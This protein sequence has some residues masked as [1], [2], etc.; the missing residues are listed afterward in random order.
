MCANYIKLRS[1]S[2][3]A[4]LN[5]AVFYVHVH[6]S[7]CTHHVY[8]SV[9]SHMYGFP[10]FTFKCM[11]YFQWY[12][13]ISYIDMYVKFS[14]T[15]SPPHVYTCK[16]VYMYMS[17]HVQ[18]KDTHLHDTYLY[19]YVSHQ[20]QIYLTGATY[21]VYRLTS[22]FTSSIAYLHM[23]EKFYNYISIYIYKIWDIISPNSF[24]YICVSDVYPQNNLYIYNSFCVLFLYIYMDIYLYIYI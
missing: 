6:K 15:Y 4:W 19:M 12:M 10:V 18:P 22:M 23:N 3:Q 5:I 2:N 21:W 8:I 17:F 24:V 1:I 9:Y 7:T 14:D 13:F 16:D 11:I 20:T